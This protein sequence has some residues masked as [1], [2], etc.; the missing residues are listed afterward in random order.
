M[1]D[2]DTF[3]KMA[4][5][6]VYSGTEE[7]SWGESPEPPALNW[8]GAIPRFSLWDELLN[9][10]PSWTPAQFDRMWNGLSRKGKVN[11]VKKLITSKE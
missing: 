10:N 8:E 7:E 6:A 5:L 1:T 2:L 9:I 4:L 3:L 11:F